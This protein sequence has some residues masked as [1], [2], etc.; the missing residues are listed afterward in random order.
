LYALDAPN[1]IVLTPHIANQFFGEENPIGK[2]LLLNGTEPRIVTGVVQKGGNTHLDLNVYLR[3]NFS[4]FG[5]LNNSYSTYLRLHPNTEVEVLTEKIPPLINPYFEQ[6]YKELGYEYSQSELSYWALQ[7]IE[8]IYLKS[9]NFVWQEDAKKGDIRFLYIMGLIAG[10]LLLIAIFNY[11][12]LSIAQA[13]TRKKEIGV[14]KVNG[15]L[16]HQITIQFLVE[17]V[18][19]TLIA[20]II[21][22]GIV[23]L[24]LPTIQ[25]LLDVTF[26]FQSYQLI[27]ILLGVFG[28]IVILGLLAGIYP[29]FILARLPPQRVFASNT[30]GNNRFSLKQVLVIAQFV[31]VI[32][33]LTAVTF[34]SQQLDFMLSQD[35][36]FKGEQ[37]IAIPLDQNYTRDRI[38]RLTSEVLVIPGIMHMGV[39]SHVPSDQPYR[40]SLGLQGRQGA[41]SP[42]FMFGNEGI[43]DTWDLKIKQGRNF[44]T[45]HPND[46]LNFLVNEA[47]LKKYKIEDPLNQPIKVFADSTY[48]S[49]VGVFADFHQNSLD[50]NIQPLA[51]SGGIGWESKASIKIAPH[52]ITSTIKQLEK[53]WQTAESERPMRYTFLDESFAQQ[54]T[55]QLRFRKGLSYA[56]GLTILIAI[57]GL[58]GLATFNIQRRR[59][60]IGIRKVLGASV[61]QVVERLNKDFLQ[62]VFI[63]LVFAIPLGW[64]IGNEWLQHFPYRIDMEWWVFALTGLAAIGIAAITVSFQ[65]VRAAVMNPV[66][67]LRNE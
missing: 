19:Q 45:A 24:L 14:R 61:M 51:I 3:Q 34:I 23:Y 35:L 18:Q 60:E 39:S 33:M 11:A 29:A 21:G 22:S 49:I 30:T 48:H 47:F 15:A 67:A 58:F 13:S 1:A 6:A 4:T 2:T 50:K 52:N 40:W 5:W 7:P 12:N 37:V 65:S 32:T 44:S 42:D 66:H 27:P 41:V 54:Y 55:A 36:G 38:N 26:D 62:L 46:S 64:Y 59:K 56:T 53:L 10:I 17:A 43:V 8:E 63:A 16:R 25:H 57:L 20:L 9:Q 31:M 28:T